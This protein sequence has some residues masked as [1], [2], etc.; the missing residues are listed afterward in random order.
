MAVRGPI[1]DQFLIALGQ[2][3]VKCQ[4]TGI[5]SEMIRVVNSQE[6]D[7][8][9]ADSGHWVLVTV[10]IAPKPQANPRAPD[11]GKQTASA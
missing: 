2:E 5:P 8:P 4:R 6:S 10:K 11:A 1:Q 7:G 9:E 3:I